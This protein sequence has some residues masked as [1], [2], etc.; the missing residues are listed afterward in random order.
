[1]MPPMKATGRNTA[2]MQ[3]VVASTARPISLVPSMRGLA[4]R[5]AEADV[6]HDVLAHHD[7]VVD[8]DADRRG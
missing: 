1:M 2:T 7:G 8:Q 3:K 4:V 6:A 5:L